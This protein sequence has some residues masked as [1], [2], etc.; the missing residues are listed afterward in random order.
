MNFICSY[1]RQL[2][3]KGR[4][5]LLYVMMQEECVFKL[6]RLHKSIL[7]NQNIN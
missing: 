1:A 7:K 2:E 3:K 6:P 5:K 4:M